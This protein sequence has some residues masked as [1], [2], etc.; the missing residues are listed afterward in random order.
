MAFK[1][2]AVRSRLSPPIRPKKPWLFWSNF[3]KKLRNR[4]PAQKGPEHTPKY[5]LG[6]L[7]GSAVALLA[8][9][10]FGI[11]AYMR[12]SGCFIIK[13]ADFRIMT[14]T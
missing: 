3:Y 9:C 13:A 7:I 2:S 4:I 11:G 14:K 1:R 10:V 12:D 8:G 5:A 6:V